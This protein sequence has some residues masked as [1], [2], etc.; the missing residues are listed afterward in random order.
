MSALLSLLLLRAKLLAFLTLIAFFLG[1]PLAEVTRFN[2]L[3][4]KFHRFTATLGRKLNRPA[5]SIATRVYRGMVALVM[6]EIPVLAAAAVLMRYDFQW[7]AALVVIAL[8]GRG[9]RTRTLLT[10]LKQ[11]RAGKLMLEQDDALFADTH[12]ALRHTIAT[13]AEQFSIRV[14]GSGFWFVIGDLPGMFAYLVLAMAAGHYSVLREE[15]LAFGWS[16]TRLFRLA[17]FLPR[18]LA[19]LLLLLGSIFVPQLSPLRA[20]RGFFTGTYRF[21]STVAALLGIALGGKMVTAAGEVEL[22]WQG[23][24]T[25]QLLPIHLVR[26]IALM[27]VATLLWLIALLALVIV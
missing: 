18:L 8:L 27:A 17:D 11:A 25:A 9:F 4:A 21:L 23:T 12:G 10:R 16:A 24:G 5:R 19:T 1:E 7:L 26:W 3:A 2:L 20:I 6:L 15:N 14:I 13:S 22:P